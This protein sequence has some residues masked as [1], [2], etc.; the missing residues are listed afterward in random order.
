MR[1]GKVN[2]SYESPRVEYHY[3]FFFWVDGEDG[4]VAAVCKT[5]PLG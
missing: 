5:V 4:G 3:L 1:Q 2:P